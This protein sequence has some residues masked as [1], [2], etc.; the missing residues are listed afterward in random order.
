MATTALQMA[1]LVLRQ[2]DGA[3][4]LPEEVTCGG[5]NGYD[6]RMGARISAVFVILVT[7]TFGMSNTVG[8]IFLR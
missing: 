5:D 2:D 4:A 7:S 1:H 3:V 8:V 6:G